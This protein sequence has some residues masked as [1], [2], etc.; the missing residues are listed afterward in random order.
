V[1]SATHGLGRVHLALAF[2]A[3]AAVIVGTI[4]GSRAARA[5]PLL[6]S[7]ATVLTVLAYGALVPILLLGHAHLR[8]HSLGGRYEKIFPAIEL[9]W[10]SLV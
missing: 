4:A 10:L 1:G 8:P 5:D 3:F 7:Y 2:I 9:L 6:R